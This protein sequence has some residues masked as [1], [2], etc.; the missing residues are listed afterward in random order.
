MGREA[1]GKDEGCS[2]GR[3]AT[4][5]TDK[6]A[7]SGVGFIASGGFAISMMRIK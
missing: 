1:R 6:A 4:L 2:L 5:A 7:A 3:D